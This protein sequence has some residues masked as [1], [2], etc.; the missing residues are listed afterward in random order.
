MLH[1]INFTKRRGST[2]GGLAPEDL[3][4]EKQTFLSDILET[5]SMNDIPEDLIFNWDQTGINLVP[6]A[7]W[8]M[9]KKEKSV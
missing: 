1:Q 2:K 3:I 6:G 9:D 7:L 5:V 8:T 4:E